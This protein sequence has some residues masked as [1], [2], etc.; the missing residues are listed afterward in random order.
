M[1]HVD[2]H[3]S[4][5]NQSYAASKGLISFTPEGKVIMKGDDTSWLPLGTYRES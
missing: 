4:Y 1:A 2:P 5:V 3:F